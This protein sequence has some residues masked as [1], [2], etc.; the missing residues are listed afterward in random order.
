MN[1]LQIL[2]ATLKNMFRIKRLIAVVV[3]AA[4]PLLVALLW[5]AAAPAGQFARAPVY[6]QLS[7]T[8]I[9]GFVLVM[10]ACVFGTN[11]VTE[12]VEQKSIVYLLTRPVPRWRIL[13][14][15]YAAAFLATTLAVW[16]S[17]LLLFLVTATSRSGDPW[18]TSFGRDLI[19][20][21]VGCLAYGG[22][23]LLFATAFRRPLVMGLVYTFGVESWLPNLPGNFKM[24]CLMVYLR[25]LA[26]HPLDGAHVQTGGVSPALAWKVVIGVILVSVSLA[27]SIFSSTEYVPRDDV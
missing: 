23:F 9:F 14:M 6:N 25:A 1:D 2:R 3:V 4:L 26:P 11:L 15:K 20:L 13:L 5:R 8:F 22:L 21:P 27:C 18:H 17:A 16:L 12:E 7:E 24:M 10:L 19:V